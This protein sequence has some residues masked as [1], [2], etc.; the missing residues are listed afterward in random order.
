MSRILPDAE[1][2]RDAA[3]KEAASL[4][5]DSLAQGL[6]EEAR[7]AAASGHRELARRRF[8]SALYLLRSPSQASEAGA[9]LRNVGNLYFEDGEYSAGEDCLAA[10]TA[11][12]ELSGDRSALARSKNALAIGYWLRGRLDDA[13]R[14]YTEAG[15]EAKAV[16]DVKLLAMVEQNLGNIANTRGD[17][18]AAIA[19]YERSLAGYRDLGLDDQLGNVLN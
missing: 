13:Q 6:M 16:G 12:A 5:Q 15:I 1:K 19:H 14:L 17:L 8:E 3:S 10:A 18:P 4:P 7:V 2:K 9:I 11:I